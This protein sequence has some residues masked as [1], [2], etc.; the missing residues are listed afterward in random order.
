MANETL[1]EVFVYSPSFIPLIQQLK[2]KLNFHR[3]DKFYNGLKKWNYYE[4]K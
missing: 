3:G 1:L 4:R 2:L